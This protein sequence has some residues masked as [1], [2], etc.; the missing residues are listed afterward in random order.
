MGIPLQGL[1]AP[2]EAIDVRFKPAYHGIRF[3]VA[4]E[5]GSRFTYP[6][7]GAE[8]RPVQDITRRSSLCPAAH[9]LTPFRLAI[10]R[11]SSYSR[12]KTII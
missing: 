4:F 8:A 6:A 3:N 12:Y 5:R 11:R 9:P 10:S 2:R 1:Q 7:G